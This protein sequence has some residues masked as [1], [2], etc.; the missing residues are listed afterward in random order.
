MKT[1]ELK[2]DLEALAALRTGWLQDAEA[3]SDHE[4]AA[5]S[6]LGAVCDDL[7]GEI[8]RRAAA[9]KAKPA[10]KPQDSSTPP[11]QDSKTP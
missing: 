5:I 11:L 1:D 7:K 3:K 2:K 8:N 6:K 4:Y 9:A 10:P